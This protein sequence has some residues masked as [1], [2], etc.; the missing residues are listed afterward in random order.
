M[1]RMRVVLAAVIVLA[2]VA[3]G[4]ANLVRI[5]RSADGEVLPTSAVV[6]NQPDGALTMEAAY[7][8]ALARASEWSDQPVLIFASLQTDW[9]LDEQPAGP[10]EFAPGGWVRFAFTDGSERG[11][12]LLS[13]VIERYSG[14]ILTAGSQPWRRFEVES[15][16]VGQTAITSEQAVLIAE[17]EYG[18]AFRRQC[19]I[20]RHE[21][22]VTLLGG[23]G[24]MGSDGPF[25]TP[26]GVSGIEPATPVPLATPVATLA[27]VGT[28][29]TW[30]VT[31][32]QST[33]PGANS[34]EMEIDATTGQITVIRDQSQGCSRLAG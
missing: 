16:P 15:L 21:A 9:P 31:Y 23:P 20:E 27:P 8:T 25:A 28:P 30:L 32:R 5:E 19:P 1:R 22:D 18:Q 12:G 26:N 24:V 17:Q 4:I 34:L 6:P 10:P 7:P 14:E 33:R 11:A 3:L 2:M 29:A 13:I